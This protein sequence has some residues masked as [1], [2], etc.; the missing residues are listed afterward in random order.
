M[1]MFQDTHGQSTSQLFILVPNDGT[2]NFQ[3]SL[4]KFFLIGQQLQ[5][6]TFQF[7]PL[8]YLSPSQASPFPIVNRQ[9]YPVLNRIL[10]CLS[11]SIDTP[12]LSPNVNNIPDDNWIYNWTFKQINFSRIFSIM[13]NYKTIILT[14]LIVQPVSI[15]QL[16]RMLDQLSTTCFDGINSFCLI[17]QLY[18]FN[19][20]TTLV[21]RIS[22][23]AR[24]IQF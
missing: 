18:C 3:T 8:N 24:R 20:S 12:Q 21:P 1:Q 6:H 22:V 15:C 17:F 9:G 16:K 14:S 4:E 19:A 23:H 7:N 10:S 5:M 2:L 13:S 11:N